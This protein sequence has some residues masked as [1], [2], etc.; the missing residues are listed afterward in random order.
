[1]KKTAVAVMFLIASGAASAFDV[2][3]YR[4]GMTPADVATVA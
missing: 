4:S 2:D 3:G 1:M